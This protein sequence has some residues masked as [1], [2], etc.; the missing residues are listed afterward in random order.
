MKK[1]LKITGIVIGVLLLILIIVPIAL[2]GKIDQIVKKEAS[3]MLNAR[4]DF[5]RLGISLVRHFPHASLDLKGL[6]LVGVEPFAEDTL[7]SADRISV[8]VN[9]MSLFGDSG[10]EVT[11]LILDHPAVTAL[12]L[13]DGSVNWDI[14]KASEEETPAD[15]TAS[16]PSSFKLSMK[17]VRI[18][19]GKIVFVDDSSKMAFSTDRL[20]LRLS[21]DMAADRSGLNLK[22]VTRDLR[23]MMGNAT[24]IRDAEVETEINLDADFKN[25]KYELQQNRIRLNAIELGIDGWV[26]LEDDAVDMDLK[27]NTSEVQFKDILSLIP[28]FYLKDFKSLTASGDLTFSASAVGR[29]EGEN[30]PKID[31]VLT[32]TDGAFKYASLPLGVDHIRLNASVFNPGGSADRTELKV[33][34]FSAQVAE[35]NRILLSLAVATPMSDPSFDGKLSGAFDL[36]VVKDVYPLGDSVS[37]GG[38]ITAG[39]EMAGRMSDVEKKRYEKLK[40]EGNLSLQDMVFRTTGLPEVKVAEATASVTPAAMKL[41]RLDVTV[42]RSDLVAQGELSNYLPYILRGELLSGR[43]SVSSNLLDL[44]QLLGDSS[45]EAAEEES[46]PADTAAL[47]AFVVPKNLDLALN[48]SFKKI[49]FQKMTITDLVGDISM[50]E[51]TVNLGRLNMN[52]LGGA[53]RTSG[54]Y[55]TAANPK[56]PDLALDVNVDKASFSRT[57][58]E[59]DMVKKFVPIFEKTGGNY[60]MTLNVTTQMDE[61]M[62]PILN[63]VSGRGVLESSDIHVQNIGVFDQLATVLKDDRLKKIEAKDV[64]ISF[65]I[66]DGRITTSPFDLK[67]GE[68]GLNLS[69]STGLDQ[70]IDYVASVELL[71]G[72]AG[73]YLN[74][75]NVNI[76]GTFSSPQISLGVKEMAQDAVKQALGGALDKL[77]GGKSTS[78]GESAGSG[79][80]LADRAESLRAEAKA[81]GDKLIEAAKEQG[82][83]LVE[84]AKNPLAKIAAKKSAEALV[85]AAEKQAQ[86]LNE[87]AE[88]KIAQMNGGGE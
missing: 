83:K 68:V 81:A 16:E 5:D 39:I 66:A 53:I 7:V 17:D 13:A 74:K 2:R 59:L 47:S 15:T 57:F 60:S 35:T 58:E 70:T 4:L 71:S 64:K 22:M 41:A 48:T 30:L 40:G 72:T 80:S 85:S 86:K 28:A 26:A 49:L 3:A 6:T 56:Q 87:E 67:L 62:E 11:R 34:D 29:Y 43:L 21:G 54:S 27:L 36:G 79:E 75:V 1:V 25:G 88:A 52:A 61:H 37:L 45:S 73:G 18:D 8:V 76:G 19:E 32:V 65:T 77:V 46:A 23:F 31:A 82:D 12:K 55:S 78:S 44:N 20:D 14:M 84:Q 9:L 38:R 51:G 10:F 50:K 33:S 69:G 63:S 42:G 24:W